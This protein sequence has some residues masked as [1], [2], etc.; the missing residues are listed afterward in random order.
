LKREKAGEEDMLL[1]LLLLDWSLWREEGRDGWREERE[2]E[3][4]R[5]REGGKRD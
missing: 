2:M 4:G 5:R 1:L 3:D